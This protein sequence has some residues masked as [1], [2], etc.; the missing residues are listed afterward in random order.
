MND[1]GEEIDDLGEEIDDLGKRLMTWGKRLMTW[2]KRLSAAELNR[3]NSK[4][5]GDV[6]GSL[7]AAPPLTR[8]ETGRQRRLRETARP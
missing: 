4:K 5:V 8:P 6:G 2:G 1:L 7:G 3:N